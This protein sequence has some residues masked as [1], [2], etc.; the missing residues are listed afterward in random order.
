MAANFTE[1]LVCIL[2]DNILNKI[3][4]FSDKDPPCMSSEIKSAIK[5]KHRVYKTFIRH[6]RPQNDMN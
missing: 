1:K 3:I 4:R 6:G 2:A 5:H